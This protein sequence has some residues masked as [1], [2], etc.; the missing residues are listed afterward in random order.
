M[1][2][3]RRFKCKY[4]LMLCVLFCSAT[5][6]RAQ[7]APQVLAVDAPVY[8]QVPNGQPVGAWRNG[9]SWSVGKQVVLPDGKLLSIEQEIFPFGLVPTSQ[10]RI[11]TKDRPINRP[12][13]VEQGVGYYNKNYEVRYFLRLRDGRDGH[14]LQTLLEQKCREIKNLILAR[15]G[16]T[17]AIVLGGPF[18]R[19]SYTHS[20]CLDENEFSEVVVWD[21][22]TLREKWR[23]RYDS[24]SV[25]A[26]FSLAGDLLLIFIGSSSSGQVRELEVRDQQTSTLRFTSASL[27]PPNGEIYSIL[28]ADLLADP[29]KVLLSVESV[30]KGESYSPAT[31]NFLQV[32]DLQQGKLRQ[33]FLKKDSEDSLNSFQLAPDNKTLITLNQPNNAVVSPSNPNVP[34]DQNYQVH[35][36]NLVDTQVSRSVILEHSEAEEKAWH[37]D[38]HQWQ[39]WIFSSYETKALAPN[40]GQERV[41]YWDVRTGKQIPEPKSQASPIAPE[42]WRN[43]E[44]R[45]ISFDHIAVWPSR[46]INTWLGYDCF[47]CNCG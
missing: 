23:Q 20:P 22:A 35:L 16:K 4:L 27:M 32:L 28:S 42:V 15:D 7:D 30:T 29:Q 8:L 9:A 6:T 46:L 36:W 33:R 12:G 3:L 24:K 13:V 25:S 26:K 14:L 47:C 44:S 40:L 31:L 34:S 45:G 43:Y 5:L 18:S 41:R 37:R 1:N 38:Y 11:S 21:A 10:I 2:L 17:F 19:G 39:G